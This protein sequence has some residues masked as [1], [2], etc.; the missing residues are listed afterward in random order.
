MSVEKKNLDNVLSHHEIVDLLCLTMLV[1]NYGKTFEF[2]KNENVEEFMNNIKEN[3]K[4]LDSLGLNDTRKEA[5]LK[6]CKESPQGSIVTFVSDKDTDLQ[7]GITK[8]VT[9]KRF[10]V[11]FRG[12]ES[13]SDW[14]YDFQVMKTNLK[15]D[16]YVHS[17]FHQ[18]LFTNGVYD[19][20][21]SLLKELLVDNPDYEI[22]ITGH[23]LGAALSTLFGY[24]LSNEISNKITIVSF[25][26]P[27]VGNKEWKKDFESKTN[28]IHY[29][30]TNNRDVVTA[31]PMWNYH[32][33]GINVQLFENCYKIHFKESY[34]KFWEYSLFR[35][36]S[37]GDH[38]CDL[39][40]KNLIKNVW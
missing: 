27:R 35:C 29:R 23:S 5:F 32:H 4:G 31:I 40:Y 9:H 20:L 6:I 11:V 34:N 14:W 21:V 7:V 25:A 10:T 37:P 17:G 12:S 38:D 26:S 8:S 30:V 3:P 19:E 22:F 1:Y 2:D 28:L 24:L 18:Q 33:V 13:K 15:R 39:Y 36:F 16:I